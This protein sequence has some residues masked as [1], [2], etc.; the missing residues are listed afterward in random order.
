[1]RPGS[2]LPLD[3][4]PSEPGHARGHARTRCN[5][6]APHA[7]AMRIAG[8]ARPNIATRS[9]CDIDALHGVL[10]ADENA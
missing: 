10:E 9:P 1:V 2:A 4:P 5:D 8:Q 6:D 7:I 3:V